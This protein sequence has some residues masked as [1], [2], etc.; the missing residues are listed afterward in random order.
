[1]P[2]KIHEVR[3]KVSKDELEI[4]KRKAKQAGATI[5]GFM[6][7]VALKVELSAEVSP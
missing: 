4:L 1:M 7:F 6:R 5:S 2:G 3:V